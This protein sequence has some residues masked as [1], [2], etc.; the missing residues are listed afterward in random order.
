MQ[1]GGIIMSGKRNRYRDFERFIVLCLVLATILFFAYLSAAGVGN[2]ALK[3]VYAVL[4]IVLYQRNELRR[5]RSFWM[6]VWS[7]AIVICVLMSIILNYPSPNL[8]G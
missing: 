4:A 7:A 8:Y 6:S 3:I 5:Q 2:I 1:K